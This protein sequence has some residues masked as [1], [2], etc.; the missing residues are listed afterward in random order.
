MYLSGVLSEL[1]KKVSQGLYLY[2][3]INSPSPPG[4]RHI[5]SRSTA[6]SEMRDRY[7]HLDYRLYHFG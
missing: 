6:D 3:A 7:V 5:T 1:I 4:K 2:C